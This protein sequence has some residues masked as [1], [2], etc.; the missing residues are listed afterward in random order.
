MDKLN[1]QKQL[2]DYERKRNTSWLF[3]FYAFIYAIIFAGITSFI[4]LKIL[5]VGQYPHGTPEEVQKFGYASL[6]LSYALVLPFFL[7]AKK[8]IVLHKWMSILMG[9]GLTG[10]LSMM[11]A[12]GI[13]GAAG[14]DNFYVSA[15]MGV[16]LAGLFMKYSYEYH[17]RA[18]EELQLW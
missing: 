12:G 16:M 3:L 9:C 2:F 6:G 18:F 17:K 7:I 10:M 4:T 11:M 15:G 1:L 13:V 8:L 5:G 14:I